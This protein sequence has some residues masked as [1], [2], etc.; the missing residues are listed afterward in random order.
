M[1]RNFS[2]PRAPNVWR[3]GAILLAMMA[4][5]LA[6]S[7]YLVYQSPLS[8]LFTSLLILIPIIALF[9][10]K[11]PAL[12]LYAALFSVFLPGGLLPD[13]LQAFSNRFLTL[14]ALGVW[15]LNITL[16]RRPILWNSSMLLMLLFLGWSTTTLLWAPNLTVG[17]DALIK[18]ILR[19]AL[20]LLLIG[21]EITTKE[22]LDGL[23]RTLALAGWIFIL[24]GVGT[25]LLGGYEV[26]SRL[27][28]LEGNENTLGGL[29]PV[30]VPAV[31]WQTTRDGERNTWTHRLFGIAFILASLVLV[32]LSGSRGSAIAWMVVVA[33]FVLWRRTRFWGVVALLILAMAAITVPLIF[34]TTLGRFGVNP[35]DTALGGREAIWQAALLVIRDHFWHGTG[36]G[37]APY[38]VMPHLRTL[39]SVWQYEWAAIHNPLLTV[40]AETGLPG[41]FLYASVFIAALWSLITQ[42]LRHHEL[43]LTGLEAYFPLVA[44]ACAGYLTVWIKGGGME[45]SITYFLMLALLLIPAQLSMPEWDQ[46]AAD[47]ILSADQEI[48]TAAGG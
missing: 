28:I 2:W 34:S 15:V 41:F 4:S 47:R 13:T 24:V 29:F 16:R 12:A 42:W 7:P 8:P 39:R 43:G 10:S 6:G 9:F 1:I 26:G 11:V 27:Q 46:Q 3:W 19:F 14:V 40:L 20:F 36:I 30:V 45:T 32:A 5:L 38:E 37:N 18:Y 35:G 25:V 17:K 48:W 22:T 23:M 21:N 33:G 44:S 31:L